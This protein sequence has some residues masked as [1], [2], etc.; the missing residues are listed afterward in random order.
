MTYQADPTFPHRHNRDGIVDSICSECLMT[1][2]STIVVADFY[3]RVCGTA[4][5]A[6]TS[7]TN[8]EILAT[9]E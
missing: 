2:A 7:N 9:P 4:E 6:L 3:A 1:I 8:T 5:P